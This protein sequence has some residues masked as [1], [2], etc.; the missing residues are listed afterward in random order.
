MNLNQDF[1]FKDLN[2]IYRLNNI[3]ESWRDIISIKER[4]KTGKIFVLKDR[5]NSDDIKNKIVSP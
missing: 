3:V 1:K 2:K 5:N 4:K